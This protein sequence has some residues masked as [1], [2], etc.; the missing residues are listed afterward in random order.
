MQ[1]LRSFPCENDRAQFQQLTTLPAAGRYQAIISRYTFE[2]Y[3]PKSRNNGANES[4]MQRCRHL[5]QAI[6]SSFR[7]TVRVSL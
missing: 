1:A 5:L 7:H 3:T 6:P 2:L 4:G